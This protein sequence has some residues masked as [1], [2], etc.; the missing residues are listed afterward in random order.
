MDNVLKDHRWPILDR[1]LLLSGII[2]ERQPYPAAIFDGWEFM[3][4]TRPFRW[5]QNHGRCSGRIDGWWNDVP[6]ETDSA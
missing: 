4:P 3:P 5:N 2:R 1:D 6:P